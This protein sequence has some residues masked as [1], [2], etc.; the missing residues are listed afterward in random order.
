M[1][2]RSFNYS[3]GCVFDIK[4]S[5]K[6]YKFV[7]LNKENEIYKIKNNDIYVVRGGGQ[8]YGPLTIPTFGCICYQP[9]TF[10]KQHIF[11]DNIR[12]CVIVD[13][14]VKILSL[15]NYLLKIGY[16]LAVVP[17]TPDA[18]VGGCIAADVHGKNCHVSGS[19]GDHILGLH[20]YKPNSNINQY[21]DIDSLDFQSTIG[22]FGATGIVTSV[23]IK[24]Y[25][26]NGDNLNLNSIKFFDNKK[27]LAEILKLS[28]KFDDL[29]GWFAVNDNV[30]KG[31]IYYASWNNDF[32]YNDKN[33]EL[34][35]IFI[36]L[37][38]ILTILI[39]RICGLVF[40]R[41]LSIFILNSIIFNKKDSNRNIF[42]LDILF[43]LSKIQGW[44]YIYGNCFVERQFLIPY[45]D[46]F[47]NFTNICNLISRHK[48]HSLFCGVKVFKGTRIGLMSFANE[49]ISIS[50]QY[51][52][53]Q[54]E[55]FDYELTEY[56]I[57]N[58]IPEYL[59]K[60]QC[61]STSFPFGYNMQAVKKW[62]NLMKKN[63]V[64]NVLFQWLKEKI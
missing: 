5:T 2:I 29:A 9:T 51:N 30:F 35:K 43:P 32:I 13:A 6:S 37:K 23:E 49:G 52:P 46:S 26:L 63:N 56:M 57:K 16:R 25:R 60:V 20:I 3:Y 64:N 44:K 10:T 55:K 19:F 15:V 36:S 59:A 39:F 8:S 38:K 17:G 54:Y 45:N 12:E 18:T 61:F 11:V 21:I 50:I 62:Q 48:V 53:F 40:F 34:N 33:L 27:F 58:N 22:G 1:I 41:N 42:M 28:K 31:K 24:I 47:N 14:S 4:E 7:R